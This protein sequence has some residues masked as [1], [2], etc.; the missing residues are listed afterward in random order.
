ML[1]IVPEMVQ[2]NL[3]VALAEQMSLHSNQVKTHQTTGVSNIFSDN[4]HSPPPIYFP[5][6]GK[7]V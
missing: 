1:L 3:G 4:Y 2:H 5:L 6:N 7:S